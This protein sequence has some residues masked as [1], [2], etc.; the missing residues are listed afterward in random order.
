MFAICLLVKIVERKRYL[1][2]CQKNSVY[3]KSVLV[4]HDGTEYYPQK[5]QVWFDKKGK[6]KNTAILLDKKSN[7]VVHCRVEEVFEN[8]N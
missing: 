8:E 1:E 6:T 3:E 7:S 5:I 4:L 2:L